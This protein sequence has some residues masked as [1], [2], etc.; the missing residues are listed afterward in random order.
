MRAYATADFSP[1]EYNERSSARE[2]ESGGEHFTSRKV[3]VNERRSK[4]EGGK[5]EEFALHTSACSIS[6]LEAVFIII[7]PFC[8]R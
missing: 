8:A 3:N 1:E 2:R 5:K 6:V 7:V 4:Q